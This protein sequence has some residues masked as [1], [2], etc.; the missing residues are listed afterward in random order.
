METP[1][2]KLLVIPAYIHI[3]EEAGPF[4]LSMLTDDRAIDIQITLDKQHPDR[5]AD[6]FVHTRQEFDALPPFTLTPGEETA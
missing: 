2:Q 3:P 6:E 4:D 5:L 1:T